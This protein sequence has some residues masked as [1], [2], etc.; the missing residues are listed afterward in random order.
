MKDFLTRILLATDGSEDAALA[1]RA[2]VDLCDRTGAELHVAHV[3][4][5]RPGAFPA[6]VTGVGSGLPK[7]RAARL[8]RDQV[9]LISIAGAEVEGAHLRTGRPART[10][11]ALAG[12]LDADLIVVGTGGDGVAKRLMTGSI[13]E[14]VARTSPCP[15][16]VVRGGEEAWPPRRVVAGDDLSHE[17]ERAG[18]LA[19][20][21]GALFGAPVVLV[22]GFPSPVAPFHTEASLMQVSRSMFGDGGELLRRR[23]IRLEDLADG[24]PAIKVADADAATLIRDTAKEGGEPTLVAVGSRGLDALRRLAVGSVS[25]DVLRTASGPV[26]V[27]PSAARDELILQEGALSNA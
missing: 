9:E 2:A 14:E 6:P 4:Q 15:T 20:S 25:T 13:S 16:L 5:G 22:L 24:R 21:I 27:F 11:A 17:A 1:A 3:W 19:A 23:A 8:L 12:E 26:L 18:E 7:A 10:I